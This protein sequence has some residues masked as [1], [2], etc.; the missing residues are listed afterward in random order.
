MDPTAG[1]KMRF[2]CINT[3]MQPVQPVNKKQEQTGALQHHF[4]W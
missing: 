1:R 3:V 4:Q 2:T